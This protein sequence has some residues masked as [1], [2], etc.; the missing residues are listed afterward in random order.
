WD[1]SRW[2][3]RMPATAPLPRASHAMAFDSQRGR[4]LLFGGSAGNLS[5]FG[6]TWQWD[7]SFWTPLAPATSP[8]ARS[9]HALAYD[10]VRDRVV[11]FGGLSSLFGPVLGDTWEWD[12]TNWAQRMPVQSPA[13]RQWTALAFD[14]ARGRTVLFGG[15]PVFADTWEWDGTNWSPVAGAHA[16]PARYRHSL[17][18][19]SAR[20]R[21]VLFGGQATAPPTSLQDTWEWD[22]TDWTQRA[23]A[24]SPAPRYGHVLAF[25]SAR[26]RTVLF[27]H[28]PFADTWEYG[29]VAPGAWVPFGT[30]C[31][32]SAGV[33]VLAAGSELRPYP[34][35]N[36][37]VEVA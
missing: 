3:Q 21:T 32:G 13:A 6:D 28:F 26:G 25:D 15:W 22:G 2:F 17:A 9:A 37:A 29:P 4:T 36:L 11:L 27:G 10:S 31:A 7:G 8:A 24:A 18:Y 20:G 5:R 19:D 1:G 14:R 12:G 35:N 33:P 30:G 23:T 34:G 16:P